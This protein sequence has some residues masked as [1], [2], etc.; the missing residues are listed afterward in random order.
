MFEKNGKGPVHVC[1]GEEDVQKFGQPLVMGMHWILWGW[2]LKTRILETMHS[3]KKHTTTNIC[4]SLPNARIDF[5]VWPKSIK[6]KIPQSEGAM[7]SDKLVYLATRP[8]LDTLALMSDCGS[9]ISVGVEKGNLLDCNCYAYPCLSIAM[10]VA[11]KISAIQKFLCR[12]YSQSLV[13]VKWEIILRNWLMGQNDGAKKQGDHSSTTMLA[14]WSKH[15]GEPPEIMDWG[16]CWLCARASCSASEPAFSKAGLLISKKKQRLMADYVD[17]I[18]LMG[19]HCKDNGCGEST[20][21][22]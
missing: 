9:D 11:G 8:S 5:G 13:K 2:R 7:S 3:P 1:G 6:G 12:L 18:S 22:P 19:W 17:G 20:K 15:E 10:Q 4:D 21:R 14:W 16:R